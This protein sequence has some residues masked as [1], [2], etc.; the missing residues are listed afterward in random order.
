MRFIQTIIF[1]VPVFLFSQNI[2][3][4]IFDIRDKKPLNGI[5]ILSENGSLIAN[6]NA[7]GIF[8]VD[9]SILKK[10]NIK[11]IM[12]Y[13]SNYSPVE[14]KLNEIPT[15]IYLEKMMFYEL[16]P[17]I[18]VDKK[19]VSYFTVNG[20]VRSWQL[21]NNK[22][23]KYGDATIEYHIPYQISTNDVNTGIKNHITQYRTFKID[24]IK[25][26]S[27]IISIGNDNGY[28]DIYMARRDLL[29]R[30]WKRFKTECKKD[31]LFTIYENGK[32]VGY[33]INNKNETEISVS[34]NLTGDEAI[35]MLFWKLTGSYKGIEKWFGN[36][37]T[38]HLVYSF[39]S[40]KIFVETKIK[41]KYNAVETINEFFID[42]RI[43]YNDKKPKIY[44]SGINKDRSFY[45]TEY[46]K[47]E[48]K[49][50]P[51]PS[52]INEQLINVNENKNTY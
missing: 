4:T 9:A 38:R 10:A 41:G 24:S 29:A 37:D 49:K 34:E 19:A 45:T 17:V 3:I 11:S 14:Y 43:I 26:K 33:A 39:S 2:Q 8:E 12:I 35:K 36:S 28:F 23:V 44:K 1:L 22:L 6:T 46:W 18:I 20:Y 30:G 15:A 50:H 21:V 52:A 5:Q 42:D 51:L 48:I 31:S 40:E 32:D 27:K 16:N 47:E 7:E 25:E 13:D